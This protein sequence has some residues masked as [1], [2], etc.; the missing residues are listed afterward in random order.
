V[1]INDKHRTLTNIAGVD[2]DGTAKLANY[3]RDKYGCNA[4][5]DENNSGQTPMSVRFSDVPDEKDNQ[6]Q[7]VF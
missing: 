1:H 5:E 7:I 6:I 4:T 2:V 3:I